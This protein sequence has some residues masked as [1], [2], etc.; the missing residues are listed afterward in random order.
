MLSNEKTLEAWENFM[1]G[2]ESVQEGLPEYVLNSWRQC[3]ADGIRPDRQSEPKMLSKREMRTAMKRNANLIEAALPIMRMI[4]ISTR[5]TNSITLLLSAD[6]VLLAADGDEAALSPQERKLNKPGCICTQ[7]EMGSRAITLCLEEKRPISLCGAEHY[8]KDFHSTA[9]YAAPL[10]DASGDVVGAVGVSGWTAQWHPHTLALVTAAAETISTRL[11]EAVLAENQQRLNSMVLSAYNSLPEA[12]LG[13]DPSGNITHANHKA[14]ALL[15]MSLEDMQGTN[16]GALLHADCK[17]IVLDIIEKGEV[18]S[19][20]IHFMDHEAEELHHCRFHPTF[21]EDK[22]TA[23]MTVVITSQQQLMDIAKSVGG[24][25]ALYDFHHIKGKSAELKRCIAL[26]R[27]IANTHS[28]VL[29]TGESGTGKELFAQA[30]HNNSP[31]RKG[32]F[33]AISCAA[34]PRDLVEAEF[35]GYVGGAFTGAR[36]NGVPGK[37][38]LASGGTLFLDE[39]NSL[40][41]DIQAKLLR[42]IQQGEITRIGATTP[43]PVEVRIIAATNKELLEEVRDHNFREDLYYRLNVVSLHLPSLRERTTDIPILA[44]HF[45]GKVCADMKIPVPTI[46]DD[47]INSL[48]E[49]DWPGNVRELYNICERAIVISEEGELIESNASNHPRKSQSV[50]KNVKMATLDENS[51]KLFKQALEANKGNLTKTAKNLGISRST[52]Y[53]KIEKYGLE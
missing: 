41:Q 22:K 26:A 7:K 27:K 38:E 16:L 53:R 49:H 43:T 17:E 32:P 42:A 23:G 4:D 50:K 34:I 24:N 48:L 47:F 35:F 28:R 25:Y 2:D 14:S 31:I 10:Y 30:I 36:K 19:C 46:T 13:L 9:C 3:K 51:K 20:E 6:G 37:F 21:I 15:S 52:L 33:V 5:S 40:P 44:E 12:I 18:S 11:R 29:I 39:V 8:C 45:I 1:N